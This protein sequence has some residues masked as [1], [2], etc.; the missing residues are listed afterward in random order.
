MPEHAARGVEFGCVTSQ[1]R[2]A[3]LRR[4]GG[5]YLRD[6]SP[7]RSRSRED[8]DV[9][10]TGVGGNRP[11]KCRAAMAAVGQQP[12]SEVGALR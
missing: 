9:E 4:P 2:A 12:L 3:G 10:V 7:H 1:G 8:I 6:E 5:R 11:P